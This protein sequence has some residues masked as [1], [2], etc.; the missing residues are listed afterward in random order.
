MKTYSQ[1]LSHFIGQIDDQNVIRTC[2]RF[3]EEQPKLW[4]DA[5]EYFSEN[6]DETKKANI[7]FIIESDSNN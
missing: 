7:M 3:G 6:F 5:L 4:I 2:E 1:I